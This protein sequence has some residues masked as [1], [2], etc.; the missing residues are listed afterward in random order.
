VVSGFESLETINAFVA[1]PRLKDA[2]VEAGVI[3]SPRIEIVEQVE[4]I[5]VRHTTTSMTLVWVMLVF[6]VDRRCSRKLG[7]ILPDLP[8]ICAVVGKRTAMGPQT[9]S[10]KYC[11]DVLKSQP[12]CSGSC[13]QCVVVDVGPIRCCS[14]CGLNSVRHS[15]WLER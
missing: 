6:P 13:M 3:G 10:P 8:P 7:T 12:L 9:N 4:A 15:E 14:M 11:S 5:Q 2:M 1:D